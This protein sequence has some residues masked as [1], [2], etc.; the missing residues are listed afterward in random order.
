MIDLVEIGAGGGS[1]A[2]V[3][4][5]EILRVGP[6]SAGAEPGPVCYGQGGSEPTVTDANLVLGR[7]QPDHFLGGRLALDVEAARRAIRERCADALGMGVVEAAHGI[8]EIANAAMVNALRLVSVQRGYDPRRFALVA[9]GGAGPVHANRLAAEMEMPT[10]IIP[11]ESRYHIGAGVAGHRPEARVYDHSDPAAGPARPWPP[12]KRTYRRLEAQG[13]ETLDR[14]GV[15][16]EGHFACLWQADLR[17]VGQSYELSVPWAENRVDASTVQ[18]ATEQFHREHDRANGFSAPEEPVELVNLRLVAVG[19][20]RKPGLR[21]RK[22]AGRDLSSALKAVAS[23]YF[24]ESGGYVSCPL[25]DRYRLEP[26]HRIEG[27]AVVVELDSTTVIH[28]GWLA[29]VDSHD[30]LILRNLASR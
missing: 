21:Q 26:G 22:A 30:N 11:P 25:Y 6:R 24:D 15:A 9:F 8:V 18:Q 23:V 28:P 3:D 19:R 5:G 14:E 1:I 17:Y 27:P 7:L 12:W 4:S 29:E 10:T 13:R 2:W 16:V 20:I